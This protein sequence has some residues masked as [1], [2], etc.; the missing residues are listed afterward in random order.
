MGVTAKSLGIDKLP[1][2]DR[3]ALVEEIW[4]GI[5]T[6]A[7]SLDLNEQMKAELDRRIDE[8]D[9]NPGAGIPWELVESETRNRLAE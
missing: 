1:I 6:D 2:E 3:L 7:E 9:S 4:D 8:A 5:S